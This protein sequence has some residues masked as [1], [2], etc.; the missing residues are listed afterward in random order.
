[1]LFIFMLKLFLTLCFYWL[2]AFVYKEFFCQPSTFLLMLLK[3]V[4]KFF[5]SKLL[6]FLV[7]QCSFQ[8]L[9]SLHLCS[10]KGMSFYRKRSRP[11]ENW[12]L[13]F[14]LV[15]FLHEECPASVVLQP[16]VFIFSSRN[17]LA[18]TVGLWESWTRIGWAKIPL[19]SS[20]KWSWSIPSI[21]PSGGT[22]I[23][24]GSP[25]PS[26]STGR[27]A[28]WRQPGARAAASA[29]ATSSTTPSV[30]RAAPPGGGATPCS[31]TAT[32]NPCKCG[33]PIKVMQVIQFNCASAASWVM[34]I[35]VE[36][37]RS[38]GVSIFWQAFEN[39]VWYLWKL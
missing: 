12:N 24:N 4:L 38:L 10:W 11:R 29:R 23:P 33:H 9:L 20:L 28:G 5:E 17:V 37:T 27:C 19:T 34:W 36:F 13:M 35:S 39:V 22:P 8:L 16:V 14:E 26:T 3:P 31:C 32:A 6:L 21:R 18:V 30:A 2:G 15:I 7:T 25:S 1:M